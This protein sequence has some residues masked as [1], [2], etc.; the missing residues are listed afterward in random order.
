ML[1]TNIRWTKGVHN[2]AVDVDLRNNIKIRGVHN[3]AVDVDLRNNIK[4]RGVFRN[5]PNI[6]DGPFS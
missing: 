4:I 2:E 5:H 6:Y 3:E 1:F